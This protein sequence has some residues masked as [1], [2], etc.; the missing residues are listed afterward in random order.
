MT[1][2]TFLLFFV[3]FFFFVVFRLDADT[4]HFDRRGLSLFDLFIV[5]VLVLVVRSTRTL[6]SYR[7]WR[8]VKGYN[9]APL[10]SVALS[11][12]PPSCFSRV[13]KVR[14]CLCTNDLERISFVDCSGA[15][16]EDF[17][18]GLVTDEC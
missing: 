15:W 12:C 14:S 11:A 13:C 17:R 4:L 8:E 6:L 16:L 2:R 10:V 9:V 1:E 18:L 3:I 5:F 7:R